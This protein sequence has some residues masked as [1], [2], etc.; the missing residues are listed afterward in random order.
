M[1]TCIPSSFLKIQI[2][3]F[4]VLFYCFISLNLSFAVFLDQKFQH[5]W[6]HFIL[7][8]KVCRPV[9]TSTIT[10][11]Y[12]HII[13]CT[14]FRCCGGQIKYIHNAKPSSLRLRVLK[15]L[16]LNSYGKVLLV[17]NCCSKKRILNKNHCIA[18]TLLLSNMR[19]F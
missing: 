17:N 8:S 18:T 1:I 15:Q 10:S 9:A 19:Q 5:N 13:N 11:F 4:K 14:Q 3:N 6:S 16:P 7:A 2:C 12:F